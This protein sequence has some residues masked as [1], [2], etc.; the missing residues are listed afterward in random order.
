M[1]I[2]KAK[3]SVQKTTEKSPTITTTTTTSSPI[4]KKQK[5]TNKDNNNNVNDQ[6]QEEKGDEYKSVLQTSLKTIKAVVNSEEA[7]IGKTSLASKERTNGQRDDDFNANV[8]IPAQI[9]DL[10]Q[11]V[12]LQLRCFAQI[13]KPK[14]DA[15][16]YK[17][18]TL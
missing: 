13:L 14:L 6:N 17:K 1:N 18:Q 9:G 15:E 3:N 5:T 2:N 10:P 12:I 4:H 11:S 16:D 7:K 8:G